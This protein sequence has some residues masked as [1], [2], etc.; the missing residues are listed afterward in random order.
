M[1][2]LEELSR[3]SDKRFLALYEALS[4]GGFGP[5]DREVAEA[6]RFRPAAI[7]KLPMEKRARQARRILR[8]KNNAEL[9]YELFGSYLVRVHKELVCGFL[10]A[11]GVPHED[12]IIED[13]EKEPEA[14]KIPAALKELDGK[15]EAEDV[16]LYLALCAEQWPDS[17][18][19]REAWE[20]RSA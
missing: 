18:A 17:K 6:L 4:E 2:V 7:R 13:I 14:K 11:T 12:G 9:C 15:H 16:T 3:Q 5:L 19:I 8:A 20:A 1:A 10:D